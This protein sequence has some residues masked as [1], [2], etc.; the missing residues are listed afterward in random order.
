MK[1][2]FVKRSAKAV[3]YRM[4]QRKGPRTTHATDQR[5]QARRS[6]LAMSCRRALRFTGWLIGVTVAAWMG[7]AVSRQT[8]PVLQRGL[9]IRNVRV[10]G[11]RQVT[12]QEVV[13]RL[14]LKQG[15]ALHQV[16]LSD[17]AERLQT[18]PWIKEVTVERLPLHELG[19][20]V[21]ERK[22]TAIVRV[23]FEHI[24]TDEEGVV[25]AQLGGRDESALPLLMGLDARA[26]LQ[27]DARL[28]QRIR[29][30]IELAKVMAQSLDG[31]IEMDLSNAVS[32]IASARGV[33]FH[34]GNDAL[35]DQWARFM[36]VK[37]ASRIVA[38]EGKKHEGSEVDLRYDNRV[39]VRERG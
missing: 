16:S 21:L 38:F 6:R 35:I 37:A 25:L 17:L 27:G 18:H 39:I 36:T 29:S 2:P 10:E 1:I 3:G 5:Q 34:F 31:R 19:V 28:R 26:L 9:E 33:R 8:G 15:I 12:K 20:T 4:N 11:I 24:L 23:G 32:L 7:M 30:S 14:A 22:P 13:D